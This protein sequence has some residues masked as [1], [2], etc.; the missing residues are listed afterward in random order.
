MSNCPR[1]LKPLERQRDDEKYERSRD[2]KKNCNVESREN[3][4]TVDEYV[5]IRQTRISKS[6]RCRY[7]KRNRGCAF[8]SFQRKRRRFHVHQRLNCVSKGLDEGL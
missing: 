8:R 3:S 7:V 1:Q 5:S 2:G 6:D 4:V